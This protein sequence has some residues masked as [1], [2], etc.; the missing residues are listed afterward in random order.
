MKYEYIKSH[1]GKVN[2]FFGESEMALN[3]N[4]KNAFNVTLEEGFTHGGI[5]HADDVFST[6]LLKILN[7]DI[8]ILRGFSVPKEFSGIVYDIGG[9]EYDHHQK[10]S[11]VRENGIPYAAF[12]LLWEQ[13]GRL[14]L[15]EEDM[16]KFDR[17][18]IQ[19]ID[20]ADNTG[21]ENAISL[22]ISDKNLTWQEDSSKLEESFESA[23]KLAKEVLESRFRQITANRNAYEIVHEKAK[24]HKGKILYLEC[25]M[26][27]KDAVK[28]MDIFYVIY[29][30]MRGGYNIQAVPADENGKR[31]KQ[32]FPKSWRGVGIQ[33]LLELTGIEGLTFCHQSGFLCAAATL[34]GAYSA[35]EL[36]MKNI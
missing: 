34:E 12:G 1:W 19:P 16:R 23:V 21:E 30:S 28:G 29:P 8:K 10:D 2:G 26:P 7:P 22:I 3:M 5:F 11:R 25:A 20:K 35:A 18:F 4:K 13:F 33:K 9:G 24:A 36:S 32:P 27:W 15:C 14:L 17:D 31:L 6:A